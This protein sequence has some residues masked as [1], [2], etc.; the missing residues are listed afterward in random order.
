MKIAFVTVRVPYPENSGGR[1][2][3]FQ[4]LRHI[5]QAH[6]VTLVTALEGPA[7]THAARVLQERIPR[8]AIRAVDVPPRDALPRRAWRALSSVLDPLPY[9]WAAYRHRRFTANLRQVLAEEPY[10]V[11]HCD[12]VQVAHAVLAVPRTSPRLLNA[13][14]VDSLL[15]R[16]LA[17]IEERP[18]RRS[19]IR[20]Q[21]GKILRAERRMYPAFDACLAMSD[22]D[23]SH[24]E[25]RM[26]G[27]PVWTVPNGVD[28]EHFSPVATPVDPR[29]LVFSGAMD[30]LPNVD[31]VR[32]FAREVLPLIRRRIP[33]VRLLVVGR[34]P[35][36]ALIDELSGL[37]IEFTGTVEDV[38]PY[39]ARAGLFVVPLRVGS[40]T[41]LK[42]LEAWAM[43]KP[44]LSTAI[45]AEGLPARDG[46]NIRLADTP[47][48]LASRAIMLLQSPL[49]AERLGAAGRRV[50][51]E[52]FSWKRV[53]N[54]LLQAYGATISRRASATAT[55]GTQAATP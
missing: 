7:E 53:G 49:E 25:Q 39:L 45:G 37:P 16:R 50:V 23:R 26:P 12:H 5:S 52:A 21:A 30:W 38:R 44:V 55:V 32:W 24:I 28:V 9:T 15:I 19:L 11:L 31:S 3:T 4:L 8:L 22:A 17:E 13:H 29:L 14:N 40:G 54:R 33:Q 18:W 46:E 20:W 10:D 1:I 47:D 6:Q 42:I 41:R 51:E 34:E 43:A 36:R 27:L 48:A 35:A 2:R